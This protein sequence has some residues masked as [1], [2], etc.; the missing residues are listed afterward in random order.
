MD[1]SRFA[2]QHFAVIISFVSFCLISCAG[3]FPPSGG[4]VDLTPPQIVETYPENNTTMFRDQKVS[5]KFDE[6]VERGSVERSIF[7]SPYV[8]TVEYDW[9][10]REVEIRFP[11]K[12]RENTT[13]V[14]NIGTDAVDLRNRNRMANTY[15]L[16]FSTGPKIDEGSIEGRVFSSTQGAELSGIMVFAYRLDGIKPDTLDPKRTTPDYIIQTGKDGEFS[17][18][19]VAL[20]QYRLVAVRDRFKNLLYDPESDDFGVQSTE[21]ALS[22]EGKGL[23]SINFMLTREDTTAPRLLK[24]KGVTSRLSSLEFSEEL[25]DSADGWEIEFADT[26]QNR[27]IPLISVALKHPKKNEIF[28]AHKPLQENQRYKVSAKEI[29]DRTRIPINEKANSLFFTPTTKEDTSKVYLSSISISD[30]TRNLP[31]SFECLLEFSKPLR[32]NLSVETIYLLDAAQIKTPIEI[33]WLSDVNAVVKSAGSLNSSTWYS[34]YVN[35]GNLVDVFNEPGEAKMRKISF[36][37]LNSDQFTSIEGFVEDANKSDAKGEIIIEAKNLN[38]K[39]EKPY[40]IKIN[41][42]D[43][44]HFDR[45]LEGEYVVSA[46]RDRNSND[47]LDSGYPFPFSFGERFT[48]YPDT[49]KARARWPLEGVKIQLK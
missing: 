48:F 17:F 32:R 41:Q 24:V 36:E 47:N 3:Q 11:E 5:L 23:K 38:A 34:L 12:L 7:I 39:T 14:V 8:G 2:S 42:P 4:P 6:Y 37:T 49:L 45:I 44:F 26:I 31:L 15:T 18:K 10:G 29:M 33:S 43:R 30:S 40:R 9:S 20:E 46:F 16:A 22:E 19:H 21:V 28:V 27:S 13:Y 25:Y 35:Q 1:V